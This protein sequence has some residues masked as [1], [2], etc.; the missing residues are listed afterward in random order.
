MSCCS[1]L[2]GS[3][4][5][6]LRFALS[7]RAHGW[8]LRMWPLSELVCIPQKGTCPHAERCRAMAWLHGSGG[9]GTGGQASPAAAP[10]SAVAYGTGTC[11]G[12]CCRARAGSRFT[13]FCM[14]QAV[15]RLHLF[16]HHGLLQRGLLPRNIVGTSMRLHSTKLAAAEWAD[17]VQVQ[18]QCVGLAE[19]FG[20][21]NGC[22]LARCC[23]V[24]R[25]RQRVR[26][27][28]VATCM[29]QPCSC[30]TCSTSVCQQLRTATSCW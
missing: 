12:L 25:G 4:A 22:M 14:S 16:L 23:R 11:S 26:Q 6:A 19:G 8:W 18:V 7:S 20:R 24:E 21:T 30:L 10:L 2:L 13:S 27:G 29:H 5:K 9:G 17:Q 3:A 1:P 15:I 28:R